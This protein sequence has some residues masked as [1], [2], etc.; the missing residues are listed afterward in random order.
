MPPVL[1]VREDCAD[2]SPPISLPAPLPPIPLP[3]VPIAGDMLPAVL[4]GGVV[5]DPVPPVLVD[6][7][8]EPDEPPPAGVPDVPYPVEV[9]EPPVPL[10]PMPACPVP[11]PAWLDPD[12]LPVMARAWLPDPPIAACDRDELPE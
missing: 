7:S 3:E 8:P 10:W 4:R 2:G 1:P 6:D 12:M 11:V 9:P 5:P